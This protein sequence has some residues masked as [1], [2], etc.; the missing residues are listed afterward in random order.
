MKVSGGRYLEVIAYL[1]LSLCF[2]DTIKKTHL[3]QGY[4][5]CQYVLTQTSCYR[6]KKLTKNNS[7]PKWIFTL[8]VCFSL[9]FVLETTQRRSMTKRQNTQKLF[10][11]DFLNIQNFLSIYSFFPCNK[12]SETSVF[13]SL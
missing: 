11:A 4:S 5:L 1:I 13:M 6:A 10:L 7:E 3:V 12:K 9:I 8:S 2:P